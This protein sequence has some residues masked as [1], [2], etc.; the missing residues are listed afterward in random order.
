MWTPL[1]RKSAELSQWSLYINHYSEAGWES[2]VVN[3]H[4]RLENVNI[5]YMQSS[6]PTQPYMEAPYGA[7]TTPDP[8]PG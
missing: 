1:I 6:S 8:S 4:L 2:M 3:S 7:G 5:L